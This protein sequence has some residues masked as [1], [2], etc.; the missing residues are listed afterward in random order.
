MNAT[1]SP[2]DRF[3]SALHRRLTVVRALEAVAL[4]T[5]GGAAAAGLLIPLLLWRGDSALAP[6]AAAL[7]L[8]ALTGLIWGMTRRP[9]LLQAAAEADRQLGLADLLA[10]ALTVRPKRRES[11]R[12][13]EAAGWLQTVVAHA[14]AACVRHAPSQVILHRLHAR[15]WGGVALAAALVLSI[16]ALTTQ[17]PAARAAGGNVAGQRPGRRATPEAMTDAQQ[18]GR[19]PAA[20]RPASRS[21]GLGPRGAEAPVRS[22]VAREDSVDA[23]SPSDASGQRGNAASDNGLGGGSGRA[24]TPG[25]SNP[26]GSSG[27]SARRN[28]SDGQGEAA[29][30]AGTAV[31]GRPGADPDARGTVTGASGEA[32]PTAPWVSPTWAD[33][34]RRAHE[35]VEAGRVPD[36]RRGLVRDYFDPDRR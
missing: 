9:T 5:A 15:A 35:A 23:A 21:P 33:D 16:A 29:G 19:N 25:G 36:A 30:G 18:G 10:T 8:G 13:A 12:D 1:R 6:T 28:A 3:V 17:E 34:A 20:A 4:G 14:D 7:L 2:L 22:P 32:P 11:D 24:R 27:S 26:V 31:V